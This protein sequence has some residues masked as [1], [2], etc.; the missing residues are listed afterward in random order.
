MKGMGD[1]PLKRTS[2]S[3]G[4][5]NIRLC[6]DILVLVTCESDCGSR[7]IDEMLMI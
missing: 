2:G 6:V 3:Q 1:W 4:L 5:S 7:S